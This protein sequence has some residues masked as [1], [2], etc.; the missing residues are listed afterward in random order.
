M[1]EVIFVSFIYLC[2]S[3]GAL[4]YANPGH[5]VTLSCF[6][7]SSVHYF[8]WYKQVAGCRSITITISHV[9]VIKQHHFLNVMQVKSFTCLV[10]L[11][12]KKYDVIFHF[13]AFC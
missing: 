4:L 2:V 11:F 9:Y 5:N 7:A 8:S 3:D 13:G 1:C 12:M 6:Y 10:G